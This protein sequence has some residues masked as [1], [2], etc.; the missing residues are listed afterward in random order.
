MISSHLR[1]T[2][3]F[4]T[5][6]LSLAQ[7]RLS[8]NIRIANTICH[9]DLKDLFNENIMALRI[10]AF[11]FSSLVDKALE[12]LK[13]RSVIE[14]SNADGVGKIDLGMAYFE[15]SSAA[16]KERYYQQAGP[17]RKELDRC[18]F[19]YSS[20]TTK[21]LRI[22][23]EQWPAKVSLLNLNQ[24]PM[25][26]GLVR[27]LTKEVLPH[28]DKLERDD[29]EAIKRF[30][31]RKCWK[32]FAFN[33]YL[34]MPKQGGELRLW[35]LSLSDD[36]YNKL[37]GSSYGIAPHLLP[38]ANAEIKPE[39][40]ELVIFN[41]RKVHAVAASQCGTLRVSISGFILYTGENQPLGLWS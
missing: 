3:S 38:P 28:E 11:C 27:A 21:A 2:I 36:A 23:S 9:N 34:Q 19:P 15:V 8:F 29:P 4:V 39:V 32:Q 35:D 30:P 6:Y 25:F 33:C 40:G 7:R 22:F 26:L 10:P 17:A 16:D 14:Y 20:P 24:G 31:F 41:S 1:S 37:K 13:E 5:P 12:K 18:F